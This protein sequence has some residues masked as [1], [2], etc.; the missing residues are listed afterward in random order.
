MRKWI[1]LFVAGSDG[2]F[3]DY[4]YWE[5]QTFDIKPDFIIRPIP[6]PPFR[7]GRSRLRRR[8]RQLL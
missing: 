3:R 5:P 7:V 6:R 4:S 2:I 8:G 1:G